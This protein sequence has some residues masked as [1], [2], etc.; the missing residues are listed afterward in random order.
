MNTL[1]L[2]ILP[3]S[4]TKN[5]Q[6][7]K[8]SSIVLL[9]KVFRS[10]ALYVWTVPFYQLHIFALFQVDSPGN[11]IISLADLKALEDL[12]TLENLKN[13]E[14]SDLVTL[15]NMGIGKSGEHNEADFNEFET[16]Y[17]PAA[18]IKVWLNIIFDG[19]RM[20]SS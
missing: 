13:L 17:N 4:L 3:C 20:M 15:D 16:V 6:R 8:I 7:I 9:Y 18:D 14:L 1:Y 5:T 11:R 2:T 19:W 12:K 10:V